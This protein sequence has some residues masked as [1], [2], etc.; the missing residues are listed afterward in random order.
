MNKNE[1]L[2]WLAVVSIAVV[3]L[4]LASG[5]VSKEHTPSVSNI[6][7]NFSEESNAGEISIAIEEP[8]TKSTCDDGN[9]CT[10]D[11]FNELTK[12]CEH[13]TI[14][15]CCGNDICESGERCNEETHKTNCVEDC[16]KTCPAYLIVS[17]EEG[18]KE[19]DVFA[20]SCGENE[21]CEQTDINKFRITGSSSVK[22]IVSNIGETSSDL[23]YSSFLCWSGEEQAM[24]DS[25]NI[26]GIVFEDYFNDNEDSVKHIDADDFATYYLSFDTENKEQSA[27]V[28]C[29]IFIRSTDFKAEQDFTLSFV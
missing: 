29:K 23:V 7:E 11:T 17:K 13:E 5:C 2:I 15:N 8:T 3:F 25:D 22:T 26:Y 6:S 19:Q 10:K 27:L 4:F 18:A 9:P 21:N 12:E 1:Q 14:S 28:N 16:G 24:E 20:M